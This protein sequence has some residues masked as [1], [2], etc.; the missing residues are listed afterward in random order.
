MFASLSA[1]YAYQVFL[2]R[3]RAARQGEAPRLAA[4]IQRLMVTVVA[5]LTLLNAFWVLSVS[6]GTMV[7]FPVVGAFSHVIGGASALAASRFLGLDRKSTGSMMTCGAFTNLGSIGGLVSFMFH[8]EP[9]YALAAL[10]R[11]FEPLLYFL[12]GFPLAKTYAQEASEQNRL[13][14]DPRAMVRDQLILMPVLGIGSGVVLNLAG[15]VRPE[16]LGIINSWLILASTTGMLFAV[17]LNMQFGATRRYLRESAAIAGI[18]Y[19]VLPVSL[20]LI[21]LVLGYGRIDGGLPLRIVITMSAMPVA[22][23]AL[24]PPSLYG[25]NKDLANSAWLVSMV[26]L[27]AVLPLLSLVRLI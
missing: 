18:K 10:F 4:L 24:V 15:L 8:G 20:T 19:A 22:F 13:R 14:L 21:A 12:V 11:M 7:L 27:V 6:G 1:G 25:L 17:G 26:V 16:P 9:G 5:P 23:N 3:Y 2:R